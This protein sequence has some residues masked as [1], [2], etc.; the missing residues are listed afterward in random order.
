MANKKKV[1]KKKKEINKKLPKKVSKRAVQEELSDEKQPKLAKELPSLKGGLEN[2][3]GKY[4]YDCKR[5]RQ[6][7]FLPQGGENK[8][9]SQI[10][11]VPGQ[12]I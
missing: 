2:K 9:G 3:K 11:S 8:I 7:D 4:L 5:G 12:S 6:E 1:N 10:V